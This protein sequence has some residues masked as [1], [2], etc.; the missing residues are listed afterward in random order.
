MDMNPRDGRA[1]RRFMALRRFGAKKM[2]RAVA[3]HET[4]YLM[5]MFGAS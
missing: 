3:G 5:K 4:L 1:R 2:A